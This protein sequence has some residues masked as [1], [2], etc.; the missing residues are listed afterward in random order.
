MGNVLIPNKMTSEATPSKE[1]NENGINKNKPL[2][3]EQDEQEKPHDD[4]VENK[5]S[6]IFER[7]YQPFVKSQ[8]S[9]ILFLTRWIKEKQEAQQQKFLENLKQLHINILFIEALVQMSKYAKY[10]KSLLTNKS[11][12]E[13]AYMVMM[14]ERLENLHM[15]V[16]AEKEIADKFLDEHL[17]VL[18]SKINDDEPWYADFVSYIVRK[19]VP[20]NCTFEKTKRFLS[21]VK[22]YFWEEDYAFKSCV[23]NIMRRCVARSE[24]LK[25]LAHCHLGPTRGHHSASVTQRRAIKH[26]LERSVGYNR[27]GWPKKLNDALWAFRM[28]YKTQTWCTPFGLI[29]GKASHLPVKIDCKTH[30]ALK[31]C[32]IDFTLASESRLM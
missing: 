11:R 17:I 7:T 15:E 23:D 20:P 1:I 2:I 9:S 16:L 30:W 3:F 10:L 8:Q 21:Q 14:D 24:T 22:V 28:A 6:S 32:N 4:G 18:K 31:Q 19:V 12:L 13:E 29:Y 27:K 25:M 26:I 5:S